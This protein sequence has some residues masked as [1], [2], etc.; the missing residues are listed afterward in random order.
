M[1]E[2]NQG[3]R[4]STLSEIISKFTSEKID[5][6]KMTYFPVAGNFLLFSGKSC[7]II[8]FLTSGGSTFDESLIW[9]VDALSSTNTPTGNSFTIL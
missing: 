4:N 9:K 2:I 3:V 5:G 7:E 8:P 6:W 1:L